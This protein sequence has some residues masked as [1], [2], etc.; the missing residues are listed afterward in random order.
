MVVQS[1]PDVSPT[2]WHLA[3][4]TWFFETFVLEPYAPDFEPFEPAF[5][6]LFNS[7]Y[8]A[9][10][11]R[12]PRGRRGVVTRPTVERVFEYRAATDERMCRLIESASDEQ[13]A[14]IAMRLTLG[15]HHEQQH[16]E[17]MLMDIKHVLFQNPMFPAYAD[18]DVEDARSAA[19][20]EWFSLAGGVVEIGHPGDGFAFD[21][22]GP[23]HRTFLYD[24]GLSARP[25]T[26]GEYLEFVNDGGYDNHE[27]WL[28]DGWFE[29]QSRGWRAPEYWVQQ[30]GAWFEYTLGGL[31]PLDPDASVAHVSW[32]E[33]DAYARWT[34]HRLPHE[35]EWERAARSGGAR[36]PFLESGARG[37]GRAPAASTGPSSMMGGVWELTQSPYV[38]YPGYRAPRGALGE[39]NGKFMA[40]Q[41]VCRG[42]SFGTPESHVRPTYRNFFYPHQR[43]AFQGFRLARDET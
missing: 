1:M 31:V 43:W 40:N 2:K 32:Y 25:V 29:V 20:A 39:Y 11:E 37:P 9:V 33:A 12:H 4:T 41:Y 15:L 13:W 21:N 19:P 5:C 10:G 26:N 27:H 34:G 8:E 42:G 23:R 22:E 35:S 38:P 17:L 16:Q 24:F 30:D 36:G 7:Y 14:E 6:Y 18:S 3:H 28:S